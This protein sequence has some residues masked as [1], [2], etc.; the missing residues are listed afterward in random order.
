MGYCAVKRASTT[1][2]L[3]LL[4]ST[5]CGEGVMP[6]QQ[7]MVWFT[8][9]E[10]AEVNA[11][12]YEDVQTRLPPA[13][14]TQLEPIVKDFLDKH[15]RL[16]DDPFVTQRI[17]QI[18][19]VFMAFGRFHELVPLYREDVEKK[20]TASRMAPRLAWAYIR[21]NQRE[22][23]RELLDRLLADRGDEAEIQFMDG[24]YWIQEQPRSDDSVANA[25]KAWKRVLELDPN[26]QGP[27]G[28]T[29]AVLSQE[30]ER[31]ENQFGAI[32]SASPAELAIRAAVA[33]VRRSLQ[34]AAPLAAAVAKRQP[35][36]TPEPMPPPSEPAAAPAE[37]VAAASETEPPDTAE[38][39]RPVEKL[40]KDQEYRLKV[41][42]AQ[43]ALAR[44]EMGKADQLFAEALR[45]EPNGFEAVFGQLRSNWT[46][47]SARNDIAAR[48]R[49]LAE[50]DDLDPRQRYELGLF[51]W[52]KMGRDDITRRLWEPIAKEDPQ[53]AETIGLKRLLERLE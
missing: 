22:A 30:V 8:A 15:E 53:L 35:E 6:E 17:E 25:V 48:M 37:A 21:M 27:E 43:I 28:L 11:V 45:I 38:V 50:R 23:A 44:G 10:T 12:P 18:E 20:G 47:V 19:D 24:A 26:F 5:A 1:L 34:L 36:P 16:F 3:A 46:T 32:D 14:V 41:A 42:R 13:Q 31:F 4:L 2:G 40:T 52:S 7:Q 49:A 33:R 51:V 39:D 9:V 29:A